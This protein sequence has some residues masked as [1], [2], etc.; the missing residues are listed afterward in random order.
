MKPLLIIGILLVF[1][2]AATP[3]Q[4]AASRY[5]FSGD[6]AIDIATFKGTY[7]DASGNYVPSAL[8]KIRKSYGGPM[9]I[10]FIEFLDYLQDHFKGGKIQI[11]SGYRS[12]TYNQ[13]IRKRGA[14]AGKASMHQYAMAA[15]I[16]MKGVHPKKIWEY[17]RDLNYGGVGYYHGANVH[18]DVGPARFWDETSSKVDTDHADENKLITLVQDKD[19]YFPGEN[20]S[21]RFVRMTAYPIGV[22]PAFVLESKK[23]E[24]WKAIDTFEESKS[25]TSKES[26]PKYSSIAEMKDFN[27]ALPQKLKPGRYRVRAKFCEKEWEAMP[28]EITSYEFV[29]KDVIPTD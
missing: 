22:S 8:A 27:F 5:F 3:P 9:E 13:S 12:P 4:E 10:R 2:S 7:R 29:I 1:I 20:M 6:G 18:L 11:T 23:G 17:V 16:Q 14:L 28:D 19:I 24:T 26:C 15:D 21:L 25:D